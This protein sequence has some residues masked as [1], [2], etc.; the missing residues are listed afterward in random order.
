MHMR[1]SDKRWARAQAIHMSPSGEL[2]LERTESAE[3][4]PI[5][6]DR[7]GLLPG[8]PLSLCGTAMGLGSCKLGPEPEALAGLTGERPPKAD[9]TSVIGTNKAHNRRLQ[10]AKRTMSRAI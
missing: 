6:E 10:A 8:L 1:A 9:A 7:S 5:A 2:P 4:S 3:P